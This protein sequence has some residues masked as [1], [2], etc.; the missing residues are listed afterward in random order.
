M[1]ELQTHGFTYLLQIIFF[2]NERDVS[3]PQHGWSH[4]KSH[5]ARH[6]EAATELGAWA[7]SAHS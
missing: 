5:H 3:E 6:V 4:R 1:K 7:H 2:Q